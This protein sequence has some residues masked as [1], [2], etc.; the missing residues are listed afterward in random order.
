MPALLLEGE[1]QESRKSPTPNETQFEFLFA[2][3]IQIAIVRNVVRNRIVSTTEEEATPPAK[4]SVFSN[5]I[6]NHL[7]I[8]CGR[9]FAIFSIWSSS[10]SAADRMAISN[11][12]SRGV[13]A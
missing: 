1:Q 4:S 3:L 9:L 5:R 10:I 8:Y 2:L 11:G 12:R 13:D 7:Q 6:F